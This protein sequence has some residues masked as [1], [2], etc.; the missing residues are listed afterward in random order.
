MF[1]NPLIPADQ[2]WALLAVLTAVA[3]FGLW[4]EQRT[5]WG[6][7]LSAVVLAIGGTFVLS[8]LGLIPADAPVYDV[9]WKYLVPLAIP[10]LLFRA[11]LK[12]IVR[13]AGP[14]L[15]AFMAGGVGTVAGTL[16]AFWLIP[17]GDEGWKLAAIFCSTYIGGSMNYVAAS[18]AVGLQT[19]DL[20]AAGVAA[21]NLVMTLYFL[22]LFALPSFAWLRKRYPVRHIPHTGDEPGQDQQEIDGDLSLLNLGLGLAIG[23]GLCALGY[24]LQDLTGIAGSGILFVTAM[25]VALATALPKH[26]GRIAKADRI[27]T[28]LMQIFFATIGASANILIVMK[29]G[30]ILFAFAGLILLVHLLFILV[31]GKLLKLDLSEIVIASNANMGGPTTAAA[32]AVARR[33][34]TLV[35]PAILCGTLGYAVATFIGVAVGAWLH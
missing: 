20:L 30:P 7:K 33:W 23:V 22:V 29:V 5:R 32:M 11:N 25:V 8:N 16:L 17:L 15:L 31:A 24:G 26:M 1:E 6:G 3:A 27:G 12:R 4:A 28:F 34:R 35:I 19:G 9:V 14:T 18:E 10:L 2:H 13:E 21:D